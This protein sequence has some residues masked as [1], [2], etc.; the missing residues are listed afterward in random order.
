MGLVK[1]LFILAI[2]G[3]FYL[4]F[5][6]IQNKSPGPKNSKGALISQ[7]MVKCAHCDVHL[8]QITA[9]EGQ[10]NHWFCSKTHQQAFAEHNTE[11]NEN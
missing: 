3:I 11:E 5:Q 8:P 7:E 6:K 4:A 9:I 2:A 10:D 1:L